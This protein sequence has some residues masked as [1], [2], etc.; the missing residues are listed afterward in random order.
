MRILIGNEC[1]AH[2]V[3]MRSEIGIMTDFTFE[4]IYV[5]KLLEKEIIL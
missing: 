4:N 2:D 1:V 5:I 3:N